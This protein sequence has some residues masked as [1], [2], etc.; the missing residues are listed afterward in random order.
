MIR[1]PHGGCY[2]ETRRFATEGGLTIEG[3]HSNQLQNELPS[4]MNS[5]WKAEACLEPTNITKSNMQR[6][7]DLIPKKNGS[8]QS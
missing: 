7:Q 5:D 2:Q 3:A 6:D 8:G 4:Y 1:W